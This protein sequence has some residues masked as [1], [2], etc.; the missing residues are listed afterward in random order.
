MNEKEFA[1]WKRNCDIEIAMQLLLNKL[2]RKKLVT[3]SQIRKIQDVI[4]I[5]GKYNLANAPHNKGKK[6]LVILKEKQKEAHEK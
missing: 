3:K 6:V 5:I 1:I 2:K 4:N